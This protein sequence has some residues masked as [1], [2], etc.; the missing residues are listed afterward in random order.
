[1]GAVSDDGSLV[2]AASGA[3]VYRVPQSGAAQVVLSAGSIRSLT[4]LRNGMDVAVSDST[5]GSVHLVRN[6]ASHPEAAVLVS[7]I[8]GV[9]TLYPSSDG[10]LLFASQ[11]KTGI[12]SI[13]LTS[14]EVKSYP[15]SIAP[16]GLIPLRNRD[17]FLISARTNQPGWIFYRD[18]AGGRVVFIPA[19]GEGARQIPTKGGVR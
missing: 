2:L 13:D 17:T 10:Q 6:A 7:G 5:T 11:S 1:M 15:T 19:A 4:V 3:A 14:A 18:G 16:T 12:A 9:E 8:D